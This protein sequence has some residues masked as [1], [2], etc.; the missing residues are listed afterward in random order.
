MRA[1]VRTYISGRGR[2]G[3][4]SLPTTGNGKMAGRGAP[5]CF[6]ETNPIFPGGKMAFNQRR[7]KVLDNKKAAKIFGFVF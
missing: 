3:Q 4:P 6:C 2:L 7:D 1:D 5:I